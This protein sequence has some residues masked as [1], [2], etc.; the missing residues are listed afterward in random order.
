MTPG[1]S[2]AGSAAAVAAGVCPL[3]V[4]SDGGGSVRLP[5]A[6]TGLFGIKASMGRVPVWPGCRDLPGPA[7]RAGN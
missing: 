5:A 1:G 6:F 3:A 4:G 2:S 7:P